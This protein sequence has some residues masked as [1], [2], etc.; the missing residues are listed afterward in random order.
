MPAGWFLVDPVMR[1]MATFAPSDTEQALAT[2]EATGDPLHH[3]GVAT[4]APVLMVPRVFEP[5]FVTRFWTI[6][7]PMAEKPPAL[8]A[9]VTVKRWLN[10]ITPPRSDLTA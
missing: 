2:L 7:G 1:V 9:S 8:P 6:T 4:P 10:S 5:D 3:A